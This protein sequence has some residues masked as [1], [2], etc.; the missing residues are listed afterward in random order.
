M[1][2]QPTPQRKMRRLAALGG[3]VLGLG[4]L[5]MLGACSSGYDVSLDVSD[6]VNAVCNTSCV[7][8]VSVEA[9]GESRSEYRCLQNIT[10]TSL[11]D[12]G[13][14]GTV[15]L[16]VPE[17]LV[18]MEVIG[19]RGPSCGDDMIIFDGITPVT[20]SDVKVP[21]QCTASCSAAGMMQP[22]TTSLLAVAQGTCAIG[23]AT[24]ASAGVLRNSHFDLVF[25]D[26]VLTEFSGPP[27]SPLVS[28]LGTLPR[29]V[30]STA[31]ANTC[32]AVTLYKDGAPMNTSCTRY[33]SPGLCATAG[34]TEVAYYASP[35][36]A[37]VT[38]GYRVVG[39]FAKKGATAGTTVPYTGATVAL[40]RAAPASR[41]EYLMLDATR[42][43][44]KVADPPITSTN[45]TGAFAV[46]TKEPVMVTVTAPDGIK[47]SRMVGGGTVYSNNAPGIRVSGAQLFVP[48]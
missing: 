42:T 36:L 34:K 2:S 8:S 9:L 12:H 17:G 31:S 38:A 47:V 20:G 22:Q 44:F 39:V 21:L 26:T 46:Y 35:P 23:D 30:I 32:G 27:P 13:L 1:P 15:D 33:G 24:A 43:S 14:S 25:P 11:R 19:W 10:M 6:S 18:G 7:Q 45:A 40:D 28:G 16:P 4:G 5:V 41:I 48:D 29:G 3:G 37:D